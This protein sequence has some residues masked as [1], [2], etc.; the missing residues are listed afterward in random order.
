[1]SS[2]FDQKEKKCRENFLFGAA[3]K[4]RL[5]C[6]RAFLDSLTKFLPGQTEIAPC[7]QAETLSL[8]S[9]RGWSE[10]LSHSLIKIV[11]N[12][13]HSQFNGNAHALW[14]KSYT[15]TFTSSVVM[16]TNHFQLLI[17]QQDRTVGLRVVN[18]QKDHVSRIEAAV[19]NIWLPPS[20]TSVYLS[21]R[22]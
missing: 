19:L 3:I 9:Q 5:I 16:W 22:D 2:G 10:L 6:S 13:H 15:S 12:S 20:L 8:E 21:T 7:L 18:R 14:L 4:P 1:M 11:S 17:R